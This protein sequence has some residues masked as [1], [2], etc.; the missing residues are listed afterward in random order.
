MK[1]SH[2][3][4]RHAPITP[5]SG[6][7]KIHEIVPFK[8]KQDVFKSKWVLFLMSQKIMKISLKMILVG[9]IVPKLEDIIPVTSEFFKFHPIIWKFTFWPKRVKKLKFSGKN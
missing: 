9:Q 6:N 5:C 7:V 3:L 2:F 8:K 4:Y 1:M